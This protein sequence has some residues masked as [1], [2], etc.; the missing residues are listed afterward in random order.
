MKELNGSSFLVKE[1]V[2]MFK[3]ANNYD[4]LDPQSSKCILECREPNLSFITKMLRFSKYKHFAPFDFHISNT[5]GETLVQAKKSWTFLRVTVDV[6]DSSSELIGYLQRPIFSLRPKL[7]V[8]DTEKNKVGEMSGSFLGWKFT[9]TYKGEEQAQVSKKWAGLG[10]ELF[11]SADNYMLTINDSV[12]ADQ[13]SRG[14]IFAS[15]LCI[16]MLFKEK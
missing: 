3:A 11:T 15:I 4:I 13:P 9:F 1:H 5:S 14:L 7:T 10:K 6:L 12:K 16:D 2:G 8:L